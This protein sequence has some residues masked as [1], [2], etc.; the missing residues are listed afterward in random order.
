[1]VSK[2]FMNIFRKL[3]SLLSI[4]LIVL[5]IFTLY[6]YYYVNSPSLNLPLFTTLI[7]ALLSFTDGLEYIIIKKLTKI[8]YI[9]CTLSI[10]FPIPIIILTHAVTT[11]I[12]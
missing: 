1:M 10:L 5:F 2:L 4:L 12:K 6:R 7:A 3:K 9:I 11:K 8:G